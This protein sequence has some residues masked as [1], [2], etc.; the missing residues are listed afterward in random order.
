MTDFVLAH[1]CGTVPESHRVPSCRRIPK[2]GLATST[3]RPLAHRD[4]QDQP[5]RA[6]DAPLPF[7]P[8]RCRT[9][10]GQYRPVLWL[11]SV[12]YWVYV[13]LTMPFWFLGAVAVF[14]ATVA[15]DR[16][17]VVLHL[18]S[19]AW[20]SFYLVSN[21]LWRARVQGRSHLPWRGAA[22]IVANHLSLLDILVLYG[23]FRPFKWVSKASLFKIPLLGWNMRMNDYV[24]IER[25]ERQSIKKMM[26]HCRRQL[27]RGAPVLMFPEG[28]R[29]VDG[30][31]QRFR[32]G[33]FKL[34]YE[35]K[36]P[37]IPV[38]ITGTS[39]ALPKHGLV[40]RERMQAVARVLEPL[41][42]ASFESAFALR[43]AARAAIT[44]ALPEEHRPLPE[45]SRAPAAEAQ[46]VHDAG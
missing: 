23:L 34:A 11:L 44:S 21:P 43:D 7:L 35:A 18:Y 24:P 36:V 1:R 12:L 33:A 39:Q 10:V 22:V 9:C 16:R 13:F 28:T 4:G 6:L 38:A 15:F 31:L 42:P 29:A 25:G 30:R 8:L 3:A 41:D 17:R 26:A 32:D 2:G 19:S 40:M 37:V 14:V 27:A 45:H 5:P 20:A 46:Q